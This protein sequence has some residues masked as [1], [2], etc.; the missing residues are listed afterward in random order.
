MKNKIIICFFFKKIWVTLFPTTF[1]VP[2]LWKL[3]FVFPLTPSSLY[4]QGVIKRNWTAYTVKSYGRLPKEMVVYN[5][6]RRYFYITV[7]CWFFNP[8]LIYQY[9]SWKSVLR[10]SILILFNRNDQFR[11]SSKSQI[12]YSIL[13]LFKNV[14]SD[15]FYYNTLF[16]L[17]TKLFKHVITI[18]HI[19]CSII[20]FVNS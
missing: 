11:I 7:I 9:F 6:N 3:N 13:L 5:V 12:N 8:V 17:L 20:L 1:L 19:S 14:W 16:S 18:K 2:T 10:Y 15:G 4:P